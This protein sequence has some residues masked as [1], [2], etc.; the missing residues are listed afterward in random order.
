LEPAEF[1]RI[2]DIGLGRAILYLQK[3][4]STPHRD[5]ILNA[6]LHNTAPEPLFEGTR[7]WYLY[8]VIGLTGD[9]TIYRK[10]ILK[11]LLVSSPSSRSW[12]G[13][14]LF[15]F[16]TRFA[17]E[18]DKGALRAISRRFDLNAETGHT[19]GAKNMIRLKG[20]A[21]FAHVALRL[22]GIEPAE[23]NYL[24]YL[25]V[26]ERVEHDYGKEKAQVA[27]ERLKTDNAIAAFISTCEAERAQ[28]QAERYKPDP[29]T[30][31]YD[32]FKHWITNELIPNDMD[33][34]Y[35]CSSWGIHASEVDLMRAAHDLLNLRDLDYLYAYLLMFDTRSFPLDPV[36]LIDMVVHENDELLY[37]LDGWITRYGQVIK[38]AI[39]ALAIISDSRVRD[40]ALKLFY[41]PDKSGWAARLLKHHWQEGDWQ[42][43]TE[44]AVQDHNPDNAHNLAMSL[45]DIFR[46]H[47]SP[48]AAHAFVNLYEINPCSYCR[49]GLVK[50]LHELDSLPDWMR[51]EC[52]YDAN[53]DLRE[54]IQ[55]NFA[56]AQD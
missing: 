37:D 43:L 46:E 10:R 48:D 50:R 13:E 30:F 5:A 33:Q 2:L 40:L 56:K 22:G 55:S 49:E 4:D 44:L 12:D 35:S 14:H 52:K 1:K 42:L 47:P 17:L 31:P 32:E 11:A 16:A 6:C 45:I 41:D 8:H 19:L 39:E 25:D 7:A 23:D 15:D 28:R 27:F 29:K 3:H 18:K 36:K 9:M 51:E 38:V 34:S 24:S 21:G 54:L 53:F 26:L 20:M